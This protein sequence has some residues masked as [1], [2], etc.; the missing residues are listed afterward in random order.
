MAN[1]KEAS[2][3]PDRPKF[4]EAKFFKY[5]KKNAKHLFQI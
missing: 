4:D 3:T 5:L 1:P 2:V